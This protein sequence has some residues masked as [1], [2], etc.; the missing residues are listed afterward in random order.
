[1]SDYYDQKNLGYAVSLRHALDDRRSVKL[2]YRLETYSYDLESDAPEF[3]REMCDRDYTRSNFRFSY[4]YDTRDAVITPRKGGNLEAF[5]S[6]SGPGSTVE[7]YSAGLSG[8][9]YYNSVW[10]SIFSIRFA[11]QTVDALDSDEEVPLFERCYLGGQGDLRG[12][13][14]RDVGMLDSSLAGDETMGGKSSAYAQF[15][16]TIPVIESIRFATFLDVGFVHED[17]FDFSPSDFAADIGI[18][19]RINLPMGPLAVDYAIPI[20]TDNAVDSDGQ[21]QFYV[22]YKY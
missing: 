14:Y 3:F 9:W 16:V 11:A 12:F 10:D 6:Y 1:M 5:A 17:S 19:L 22:D 8:S 2:E 21:F 13:R 7:T 15:E 20:A 18:G 4:E